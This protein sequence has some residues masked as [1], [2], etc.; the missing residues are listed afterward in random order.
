MGRIPVTLA[1]RGK[2]CHRNVMPDHEQVIST[3]PLGSA[4]DAEIRSVMRRTPDSNQLQDREAQA[5]VPGLLLVTG[6]LNI[7]QCIEKQGIMRCKCNGTT[8]SFPLMHQE[9]KSV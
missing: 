2:R 1:W 9:I 8:P 6:S 7:D 5:F 3:D 4:G